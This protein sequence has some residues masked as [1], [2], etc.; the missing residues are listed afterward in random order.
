MWQLDYEAQARKFLSKAGK[1]TQIQILQ[2]LKKVAQDPRSFG[3]ALT[4]GLRGIWRYRVGD[5]RILCEL[6][7]QELV[8]L[9]IDIWHRSKTYKN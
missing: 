9:A 7:N 1:R 5:Y 3:K 8:V 6:K 4:G 2:Y